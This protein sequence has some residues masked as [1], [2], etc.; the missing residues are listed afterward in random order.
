VLKANAGI[1]LED[2][3]ER[4][5][6]LQHAIRFVTEALAKHPGNP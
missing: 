5:A 3:A 4:E 1:D 6:A 2:P